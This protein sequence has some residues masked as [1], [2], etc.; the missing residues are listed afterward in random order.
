MQDNDGRYVSG[1]DGAVEFLQSAA[2]Q[3][4]FCL[5]VSLVNP[6]DVH[7]YTQNWAQKSVGYPATIPDMG[8]GLPGNQ[9][10]PL[11]EKPSAQLA[12]RTKFD[13][14]STF[15]IDPAKGLSPAGY[16]NF[17]A[18]LQ[19]VVDAQVCAVLDALDGAKLTEKTL[20]VRMGDHGEMGMSHGLREKMYVAYDEAIRVPFVVSNPL[21]FDQGPVETAALASLI[22]LVPTL[23]SVAGASVP[24]SMVGKDLT[25]VLSGQATSVQDAVLYAYD[26]VFNLDDSQVATHIRAVRTAGN[27]YSIYFSETSPDVPMEFEL[28]DLASD[29]GQLV[30]LLAPQNYQ[31]S[32]L[33]LWAELTDTLLDLVETLGA[34]PKSAALPTPSQ[35]GPRLVE[36]TGRALDLAAVAGEPWTE[37]K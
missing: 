29:P 37:G 7:V 17:Y 6:H 18:Y 32:I 20:V 3:Q 26:D 34:Q 5:V 4:P 23:A 25:P 10:D 13:A 28:Y 14:S 27:L 2:A 36:A 33:P 22:D 31:P 8:V 16:V 15:K 24:S 9:D 19:T 30:N 12:F 1:A 11:T 21:A 35:L